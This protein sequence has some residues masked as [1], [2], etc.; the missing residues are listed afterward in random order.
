MSTSTPPPSSRRPC[1]A[2]ASEAGLTYLRL[3]FAV[4]IVFRWDGTDFSAVDRIDEL[5]ARYRMRV[6]GVI[7]ETPWHIAGCAGVPFELLGRCAP[8]AEHEATWRD[9]VS[10]VVRRARNVRHWELGN[11][12]DDPRIF[13]GSPSDYAR[14][15]S[16][17]ADGIRAARPRRGSRSAARP[18]R[19]AGRPADRP[20]R[21]RQR[22]RA[23]AAAVAAGHGEPGARLLPPHGLRRPPVGDRGRLS[24][25]A[26]PPVGSGHARRRRRS[27]A[28]DG[29]RAAAA[30]RGR[31]RRRLRLLPRQPRVRAPT[32]RSARRA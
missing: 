4:G 7:T 29:A 32:A 6:L 22:P 23:R 15:A 21:H 8:A 28:L 19:A 3:D 20:L 11:E 30:A 31:R 14:W 17:A 27:G 5:A 12:P 18:A 10:Q 13:I 16:L 2:P 24:V 1:S 25:P 9:M 26:G